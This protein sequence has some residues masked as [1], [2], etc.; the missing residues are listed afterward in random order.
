VETVKSLT[1]WH[2][3]RWHC[4]YE[5]FSDAFGRLVVYSGQDA[6]L[7]MPKVAQEDATARA[8][9]LRALAQLATFRMGG[10]RATR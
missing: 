6:L 5:P 10:R 4:V 7:E 3:E 2:Y 8:T 9:G 1:L